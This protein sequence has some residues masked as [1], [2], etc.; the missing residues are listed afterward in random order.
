MTED[1]LELTWRSFLLDGNYH[2]AVLLTL[3]HG[4]KMA[5]TGVINTSIF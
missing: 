2:E 5:I 4:C 3:P 1:E